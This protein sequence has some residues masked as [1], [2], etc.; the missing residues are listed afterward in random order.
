VSLI[1]GFTPTL[2]NSFEVLHADGGIFGEFAA[3]SLPSLSAGLEWD[4]IYSNFAVL[5]EVA[6]IGLTGDYNDDGSVDAADYVVWRKNSGTNNTL[7]N[8]PIGGTIGQAQFDQW[9][10][11]FGQTAGG[12][13][14]ATKASAA[15][16]EP[17]SAVL[18]LLAAATLVLRRTPARPAC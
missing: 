7:P 13:A 1:N 3:T 6:A 14:S 2:G 9:R 12:G 15:T 18:L 10:A 8:D 11:H 16:P 17:A 4:L 5:L